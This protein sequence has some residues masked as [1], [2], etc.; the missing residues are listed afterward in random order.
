MK[1]RTSMST[2]IAC[3]LVFAMALISA[4][5]ATSAPKD[6]GIEKI[7]FFGENRSIA[8]VDLNG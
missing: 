7:T 4:P 1:S 6:N 2:L 5:T 8:Y 3:C